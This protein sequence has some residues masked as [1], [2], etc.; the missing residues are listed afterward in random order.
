[1][2]LAGEGKCYDTFNEVESC[3]DFLADPK[4]VELPQQIL[5]LLLL[6]SPEDFLGIGLTS[7]QAVKDSTPVFILL[8]DIY[9]GPMDGSVV[10][11][12]PKSVVVE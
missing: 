12:D 5:L 9:W 7:Q 6:A 10:L 2:K 3:E 8:N 11:F 4:G 1:M